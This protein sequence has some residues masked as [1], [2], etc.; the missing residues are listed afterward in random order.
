M[1]RG[2]RLLVVPLERGKTTLDCRRLR[3]VMDAAECMYSVQAY[4]VG[5]WR[6]QLCISRRVPTSVRKKLPYIKW[7]L[8]G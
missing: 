5:L 2:D 4:P 1:G 6:L 3:V 7:Y 8:P